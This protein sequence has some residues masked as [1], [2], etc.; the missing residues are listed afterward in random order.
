MP[1]YRR[2]LPS[3]S[4][5]IAFEAAAR[6]MSFTR[7]AE[8]IGVTQAA[9]SRQ[10]QTLETHLG[11]PLFLRRHRSLALTERGAILACALAES[12]ANIATAVDT[13]SGEARPDRL[14]ISASVA[15][16]HFW[17]LPRLAAFRAANPSVQLHLAAQDVA[18]DLREGATDLAIRYGEGRWPD[19]KARLLLTDHVYP[20]CS[21]DYIEHHGRPDCAA[22]I[23][24]HRLIAAHPQE[25]QWVDWGR[26]TASFGLPGG[27][28][29]IAL[30]CNLYTDAVQAALSGAGIALGWHRLIEGLVADGRLVRVA[31]ESWQI[32]EAYYL[33]LN[34]ERQHR[35]VVAAFVDWI[36]ATAA[37][38]PPLDAAPT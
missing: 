19:G 21:P 8:E 2:N 30:T 27:N 26:W 24:G 20:V 29:E 18:G 28:P 23:A 1:D 22:D 37:A 16:S 13:V 34:R 25:A 10:I 5:L 7:A 33:I 36:T 15:F 9:V 17:L 35:P 4:A 38:L 3:M 11:F 6:R 31:A 32:R 14:V 12:L